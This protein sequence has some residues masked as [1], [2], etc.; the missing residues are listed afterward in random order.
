MIRRPPRSTQSRSS[1]ASDVY[2]RQPLCLLNS[3]PL[4]N[5]SGSATA[6][7]SKE[8]VTTKSTPAALV[9]SLLAGQVQ[10]VLHR[11]VKFLRQLYGVFHTSLLLRTDRVE[12]PPSISIFYRPCVAFDYRSSYFHVAIPSLKVGFHYPSSRPEFTGRVDGPRT[13]VHFLTPVNSGR[14]LG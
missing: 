4:A 3:P 9:T 2:K 7:F 1:A 14:E 10:T 5:T 13:R 8:H 12:F 6:W 11:G